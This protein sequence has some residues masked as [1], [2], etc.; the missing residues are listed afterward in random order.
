[1]TKTYKLH[2]KLELE[3]IIP[4]EDYD[5]GPNEDVSGTPDKFNLDIRYENLEAQIGHPNTQ[6]KA[7]EAAKI[8]HDFL[9]KKG[10][11]FEDFTPDHTCRLHPHTPH[12]ADLLGDG[13][14]PGFINMALV[15]EEGTLENRKPQIYQDVKEAVAHC[16][17]EVPVRNQQNKDARAQGDEQTVVAAL[18]KFDNTT[19]NASSIPG[20]AK[21]IIDDLAIAKAARKAI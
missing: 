7:F 19:L 10:Y 5:L 8:I 16:R 4:K 13:N 1:M 17:A 18:T 20:I 14:A 11:E 9:E 3:T 15:F 2:H 6:K 21:Q 12:I